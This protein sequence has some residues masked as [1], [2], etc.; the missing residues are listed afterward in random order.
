M[1]ESVW[2]V[3]HDPAGSLGRHF[4]GLYHTAAAAQRDIDNRIAR[5]NEIARLRRVAPTYQIVDDW[6]LWDLPS[7][8]YLMTYA[9][10]DRPD[11]LGLYSLQAYEV[12]E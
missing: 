9:R 11:E 4:E 1:L 12:N 8:V 2:V 5:S 10:E 7:E 3:L 6:H